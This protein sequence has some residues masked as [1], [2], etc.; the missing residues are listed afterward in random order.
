MAISVQ[1]AIAGELAEAGDINSK[2]TLIPV[3]SRFLGSCLAGERHLL[4]FLRSLIWFSRVVV[5]WERAPGF[6]SKVS[7]TAVQ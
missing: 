7:Q 1:Q 5:W 2:G 6:Q 3:R 4:G